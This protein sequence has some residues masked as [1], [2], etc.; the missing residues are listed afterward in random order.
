M[1][2]STIRRLRGRSVA[3]LS[4]YIWLFGAVA[5]QA[6]QSPAGCNTNGLT[7]NISRSP[8]SVLN[9]DSVTY[10]FAV[11][12]LDSGASFP[13][14][15]RPCARLSAGGTWSPARTSAFAS[16]TPAMTLIVHMTPPIGPNGENPVLPMMS[17]LPLSTIGIVKSGFP[18]IPGQ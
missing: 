13:S 8:A 6:H 2:T 12:N 1:S 3:I 10:T 18:S 9:G 11:A 7:V 14:C 16:V 17:R 4:L 15:S 5:A